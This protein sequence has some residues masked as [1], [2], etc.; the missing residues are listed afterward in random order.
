MEAN[1]CWFIAVVTPNTEKACKEKLDKLIE[2]MNKDRYEEEGENEDKMVKASFLSNVNCMSGP[3]RVSVCGWIECCAPV[4]FSS[5]A[6]T[7]NVTNWLARPSSSF[8]S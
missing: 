6:P 1:K 8:T 7:R 3:V 4:T 2:V 5:V